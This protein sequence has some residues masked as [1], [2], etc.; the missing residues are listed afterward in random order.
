MRP[1]FK[2]SY[3]RL[4]KPVVEHT[5]PVLESEELYHYT[6]EAAVLYVIRA[7]YNSV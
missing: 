2:V 6:T 5:T 3:E 4:E 7:V 1:R